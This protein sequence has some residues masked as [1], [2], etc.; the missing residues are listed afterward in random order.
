MTHMLRT[1]ILK[2]GILPM[3]WSALNSESK[4][5]KSFRKFLKQ[6][7][8][9]R[10]LVSQVYINNK[11]CPETFSDKLSSPEAQTCQVAWKRLDKLSCLEETLSN[12][13]SC[14]QVKQ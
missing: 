10:P 3:K 5:L 12:L 8:F 2:E 9:S 7:R 14:L 11:N 4:Q 6:T 1:I 13:S